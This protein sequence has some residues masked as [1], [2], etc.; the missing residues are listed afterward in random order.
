M[1]DIEILMLDRCTRSEAERFLKN[2]TEVFDGE[3]FAEH[4]EDY[5]ADW[6]ADE[7]DR[8]EY[9]RM[10]ETKKPARDWGVVEQDGKYY[11]I[12]YVN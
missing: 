8:E 2:G 11:F 10:L 5:M 7:E 3:E 9:R 4:F 1:K 6:G 12:M